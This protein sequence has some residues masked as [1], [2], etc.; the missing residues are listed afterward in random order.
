MDEHPERTRG[1]AG[2]D[3]AWDAFVASVPGAGYTQ[4]SCW[5]VTRAHSGWDLLRV[6]VPQ[7]GQI[8][9]GVQIETKRVGRL[10]RIGFIHGGPVVAPGSADAVEEVLDR[11][12][13]VGRGAGLT[14]LAVRPPRSG[15]AAAAALRRRGFD[16]G[17]LDHLYLYFD[18]SVVLDLTPGEDGLM[19]GLNKKR[20]QNVRFA[21]KTGV[22]V[23]R[24]TAADLPDFCR[25]KD[26]HAARLGYERRDDAYFSTL[27]D[28][29]SDGGHIEL[30]VGEYEGKPLCAQLV[31]AFGDTTYHI[32]RPWSGEHGELSGAELVEWEAIRWAAASGYRRADLGGI[33]TPVGRSVVTGFE[34]PRAKEHGASLFKLRWGGKVIEEPPFLDHVYNPLV[35]S[36][37]RHIPASVTRSGWM[38]RAAKRLKDS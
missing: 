20:R 7:D 3:D 34:E 9:A 13:A 23:R 28:A 15:T 19:A 4:S 11:A 26:L 6:T 12:L 14:Y 21:A 29:L 1:A 17:L 32:D 10:G 25:L 33:E 27:W 35:R 22:V 8:V 30:F 38:E 24:G 36:A 2:R 5:G 18:Y 37:Y 31:I 16:R